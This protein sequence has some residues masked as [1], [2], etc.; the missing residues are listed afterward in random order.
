MEAAK[1]QLLTIIDSKINLAHNIF[2]LQAHT[3]RM[4]CLSMGMAMGHEETTGKER[5]SLSPPNPRRLF[6]SKVPPLAITRVDLP[7]PPPIEGMLG[8]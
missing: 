6:R 3:N 2:A 5:K 8:W 4:N 1:I 7:P